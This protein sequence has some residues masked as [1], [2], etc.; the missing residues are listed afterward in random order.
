ML[1]SVMN[2]VRFIKE[3]AIN[4][5]PSDEFCTEL[6]NYGNNSSGAVKLNLKWIANGINVTNLLAKRWKR[7]YV[8]IT[9]NHVREICML[10]SFLFQ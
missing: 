1:R 9:F 5:M 3:C 6:K 7:G 10:E 8:V 4:V 2:A